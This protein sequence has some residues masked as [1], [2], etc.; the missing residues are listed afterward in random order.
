MLDQDA[1]K[2]HAIVLC[3]GLGTRLRPLTHAIPKPAVPVGTLPAALRT[4]QQLLT[5]GFDLVHINS[6][7]LASELESELTAACEAHG[8]SPSRLRFWH[9][10][11]LLETGGGIAR[12][13]QSLAAEQGS[14]SCKDTLVVSGD[15]V[16]DV[17]LNEMITAW[18]N[19]H[20][21]Q[22]SLMVTRPLDKPRKDITWVDA[23][24]QF[25]CGFG[26]DFDAINARDSG[27]L[28][29][30]FSNHQII[31]GELIQRATVEKKSSIDLFYRSAL[32]SGDS[33]I[34]VPMPFES[35]WFDIGTPD[36]YFQCIN[37]LNQANTK[38]VDHSEWKCLHVCYPRRS[39][40]EKNDQGLDLGKTD[41]DYAGL[42]NCSEENVH[43][44]EKKNLHWVLL[45][46]LYSHPA[47]LIQGVS[48][49]VD[50]L[51]GVDFS[52]KSLTRS[53]AFSSTH[54]LRL[55]TL[56]R[57][58][59]SSHPLDPS[60]SL[61]SVFEGIIHF[62]VPRSLLEP[63]RLSHPLLVPLEFLLS[64]CDSSSSSA[65]VP[66]HS[67]YWILITPSLP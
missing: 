55:N 24:N 35:V 4:I 41:Q 36:S 46:R 34:H 29:R 18:K 22:S 14:N 43:K 56:S 11:E 31:A 9:E 8:L 10:P 37:M 53:L 17:P 66:S 65:M 54:S 16:A 27:F 50:V 39:G 59:S 15:I 60:P 30:V 52:S 48:A 44:K 47:R 19:R 63:L 20:S 61:S 58:F 38:S 64:L 49:L 67:P 57:P 3:A 5:A 2:M 42:I 33:I 32:K 23:T 25:V 12:I 40:N 45:G 7:Y 26:A 13:C 51:H 1:A 6:H 28:E 21:S 62:P